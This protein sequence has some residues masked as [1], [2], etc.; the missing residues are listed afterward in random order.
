MKSYIEKQQSVLEIQGQNSLN[1]QVR[2]S[3]AKNSALVLMAGSILCSENCRLNNIP[4]LVDI[5]GDQDLEIIFTTTTVSGGQVYV[6]HH[7]GSTESCSTHFI[8]E[9]L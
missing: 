1:G 7:N 9:S 3:G 5:D 2:I 8:P 6:I 4:A